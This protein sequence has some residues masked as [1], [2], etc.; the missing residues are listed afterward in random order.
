MQF[1]VAQNGTVLMEQNG[2]GTIDFTALA[3]PMVLLVNATPQ[4]NVNALVDV[5]VQTTGSAPQLLFDQVQPV[6]VSGGFISKSILLGT[7]GNYEVTL[8][9]L[10]FP[11]QF[12]N[13]A[14][15]GSS[16]GAV[17]GTIYSGGSFP[18]TA[19]PGNYQFTLVATPT[20]P[21]QYGLYGIQIVNA[22]PQVTLTASPMSVTVD[23]PT[24]LSWTTSSATACT[25]SGGTFT[26]AEP[27]GSGMVSVVV[28]ATT[29]Y[30]L[31]CTGAG[32]SASAN[33]TVTATGAAA[34]SG[35]GGRI[36]LGLIAML[37]VMFALVR[38]R[39]IKG[40]AG[41]PPPA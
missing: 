30:T 6:S 15:I 37:A 41:S 33:V 35:G 19:T 40:P 13:L 1:A 36:G 25:A 2:V 39:D 17:L 26:G 23:A 34:K 32:G 3:G 16:A 29:T 7:S 18:I 20:A 8:T 12:Q 4:T 22:P 11:A 14:L 27:V 9:D 5:N 31:T 28:A 24:T 21:Q 10:A 38:I